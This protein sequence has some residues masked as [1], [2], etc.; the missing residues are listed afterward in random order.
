MAMATVMV[1]VSRWVRLHLVEGCPKFQ[2]RLEARQGRLHTSHSSQQGGSH[3]RGKTSFL[4]R[5]GNHGPKAK[6]PRSRSKG[7]FI[8]LFLLLLPLGLSLHVTT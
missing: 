6:D 3:T 8:V 7:R 5:L 2:A 4:N 1:V